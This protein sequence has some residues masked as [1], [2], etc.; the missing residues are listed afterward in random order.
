MGRASGF[1][2]P[3]RFFGRARTCFVANSPACAASQNA[4]RSNLSDKHLSTPCL[5]VLEVAFLPYGLYRSSIH[6]P[7]LLSPP[8]SR[9]GFLHSSIRLRLKGPAN[10]KFL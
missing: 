2:A 1:R 3:R 10:R 4:D 8:S 6:D 7:I 5:N 9:S